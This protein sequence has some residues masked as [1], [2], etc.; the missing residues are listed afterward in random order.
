MQGVDLI[1]CPELELG[2][3]PAVNPGC[4]LAHLNQDCS[5]DDAVLV[6]DKIQK[7]GAPRSRDHIRYHLGHYEFR[8]AQRLNVEAYPLLASLVSSAMD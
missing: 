8:P 2:P 1:P 4:N 3:L 7:P 5:V 6:H